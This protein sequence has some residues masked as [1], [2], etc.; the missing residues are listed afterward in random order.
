MT[1]H[2]TLAAPAGRCPARPAAVTRTNS[3][4]ALADNRIHRRRPWTRNRDWH[5]D[6]TRRL[7][8]GTPFAALGLRRPAG[9]PTGRAAPSS[10][11]DNAPPR[12][13]VDDDDP[14]TDPD[15]DGRR[16]G[17]DAVRT[18]QEE[19]GRPAGPDYRRHRWTADAAGFTPDLSASRPAA[20]DR[21]LRPRGQPNRAQHCPRKPGARLTAERWM[22]RVPPR[23]GRA[24]QPGP[25]PPG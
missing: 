3:M 13:G 8:A 20:S 15:G 12:N 6:R 7:S 11:L 21:V 19:P 1:Q 23:A 25:S 16:A 17:E 9:S 24:N 2:D 14:P 18:P 10:A 22:P 4:I 5:R